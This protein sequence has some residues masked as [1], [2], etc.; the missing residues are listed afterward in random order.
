MLLELQSNGRGS[1]DYAKNLTAGGTGHLSPE[2]PPEIELPEW[3]VCRVCR[4]MPTPEENKCCG[5]C[6]CV[7]SYELFQ[8][9]YIDREVLTEP[10]IPSAQISKHFPRMTKK[11]EQIVTVI[12]KTHLSELIFI[13][14]PS[15]G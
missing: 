2:G 9:I 13:P 14:W 3:C 6:T 7:T 8:N 5:K 4:P 15:N 12:F 11:L 1:L 10:S